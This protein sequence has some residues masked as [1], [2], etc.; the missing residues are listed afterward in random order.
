MI[1]SDPALDCSLARPYEPEISSGALMAN[2]SSSSG[3]FKFIKLLFENFSFEI[4]E[5]LWTN[6]RLPIN[7]NWPDLNS[8]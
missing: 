2:F 7:G 6:D 1:S 8:S 3:L 4:D 5:F